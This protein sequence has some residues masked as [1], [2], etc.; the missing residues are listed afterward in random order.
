M[1]LQVTTIILLNLLKRYVFERV[2]TP[3]EPSFKLL[4]SKN[5]EFL[6]LN[7]MFEGQCEVVK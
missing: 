4:I 5:Q 3:M 2:L 7:K 6:F 1:A